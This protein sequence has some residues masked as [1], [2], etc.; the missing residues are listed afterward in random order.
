M[1]QKIFRWTLLKRALLQKKSKAVLIV[2][3]A[4]MGASVVAALLNLNADLRERM[5]REL[6]DYGPNV[7]L[8]PQ[9]NKTFLDG[10]VFRDL[11]HSS[12]RS[13]ILAATPEM[14]VPVRLGVGTPAMLVGADLDQL[15]KL[16]PGWSWNAGNGRGILVGVRLAK[17]LWAQQPQTL[18]V[19]IGDQEIEQPV[20]GT[21]ESGEAEDDQAFL[22]LSAV[23]EMNAAPDRFHVIA[24]SM[25]GEIE[26]VQTSLNGFVS[27]HSGVS[28][29]LLRKIAASEMQI[30]DKLSRM[31]TWVILIILAILFFCVN[32]TVSA[33]LLSR[34]TEIALMRVL[35]ARRKQ[36]MLGLTMELLLLGLVG[37]VLGYLL[38]MFMAQVLGRILFHTFVAPRLSVLFITLFSSLL[39]MVISSF[40]PI[41]RIINRQAA[42]V[43]KEA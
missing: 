8:V 37:G 23:Q 33:I 22:D 39:M 38:G 3:A 5:N 40:L 31:M 7:I 6:R 16:Y 17:K 20:A 26:T 41:N 36:I 42:L 28:Y 4:A 43:L 12:F 10:A 11:Q 2:L 19:K 1:N 21:L 35:G 14:F 18:I 24:V 29:N 32:T 15:H 13:R 34:Q 9:A 30:L 25:L 27:S